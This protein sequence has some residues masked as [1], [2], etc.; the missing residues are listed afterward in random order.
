M[1]LSVL[2]KQVEIMK[3]PNISTELKMSDDYVYRHI[4]NSDIA[5]QVALDFLGVKTT[6]ELMD[7]VVPDTIRLADENM[8]KHN[9]VEL[10]GIDSEIL[11]LERMRQIAS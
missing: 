2:D 9:G 10:E 3:N 5:T 6:N 4:G 8:F 1:S 7:Q 11:M